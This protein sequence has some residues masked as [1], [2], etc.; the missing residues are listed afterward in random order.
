MGEWAFAGF[1]EKDLPRVL[2]C[3]TVWL[4]S[5]AAEG[6]AVRIEI[7]RVDKTAALHELPDTVI[8]PNYHWVHTCCGGETIGTTQSVSTVQG[9]LYEYGVEAQRL[10]PFQE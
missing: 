7:A 2:L 8:A 5:S 6:I 9:S 10:I 3:A 4:A 1:C